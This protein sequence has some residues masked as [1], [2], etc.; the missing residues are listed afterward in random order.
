MKVNFIYF[1]IYPLFYNCIFHLTIG[2]TLIYVNTVVNCLVPI[3]IK[4][5][6]CL[7]KLLGLRKIAC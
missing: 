4:N 2:V 3:L 7:M 1:E 5:L 6:I